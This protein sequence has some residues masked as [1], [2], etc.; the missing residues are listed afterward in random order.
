VSATRE[1]ID[2]T[3]ASK[4]DKLC[5][6]SSIVNGTCTVRNKDIR[7]TYDFIYETRNN[8]IFDNT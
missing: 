5:S 8:L 4:V 2:L 7:L 3:Q 1:R 6:P